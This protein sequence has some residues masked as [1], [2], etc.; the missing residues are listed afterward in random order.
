LPAEV[1]AFA[2]ERAYQIFELLLDTLMGVEESILVDTA[3]INT[4]CGMLL[5]PVLDLLSG[6][7]AQERQHSDHDHRQKRSEARKKG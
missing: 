3:P 1:V 5:P 4:C 2:R 6:N 7:H